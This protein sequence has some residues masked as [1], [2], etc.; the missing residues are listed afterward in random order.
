MNPYHKK[1]LMCIAAL[2][3]SVAALSLTGGKRVWAP[4]TSRALTTQGGLPSNRM[5]DMV[6]DAT[7]YIWLGTANGLCRYDGYAFVTFHAQDA[8]TRSMTDNVGTLHLDTLN[9]LLWIRSATFHYS[10]LDLRQGR[11]VNFAP[12]C[13]TRNTYERF[14]TEPGGIWMYEAKAG[15]RH[16][17]YA[18]GGF[19]C[20][21]YTPGNGLPKDCKVK[22]IVVGNGGSVWVLTT[23]GLLRLNG[24]GAFENLARGND[25]MMANSWG[26]LTYFLTRK[27]KVM[28]FDKE[29]R[30]VRSANMPQEMSDMGAV[31]GNMIW[32]GHWFIMKR[33]A[34]ISMDCRTMEFSMPAE[35]QMDYGIVL[36]N[37]D[38]N[39]CVADKHGT[40]WLFTSSGKM[41]RMQ[42]LQ[43]NDI[44]IT[45]KRNYSTIIADDG[46]FYIATY[47]SG[48]YIYDPASDNLEHFSAKDPYP[49]LDTDYL[50]NIH[51]DRDGNVWIGQEDAGVTMLRSNPLSNYGIMM[52]DPLHQGEKTNFIT[53]LRHAADG[54]ILVTTQSLRNYL[55]RKDG[56]FMPATVS[57]TPDSHT[58]SLTD[59]QGRTWI[60]TW[61]QGLIMAVKGKEGQRKLTYLLTRSITESRINALTTDR[62]GNLWVATYNGIYTADIS[63]GNISNASFRHIG[64]GDRLPTN[65]ITC[66]LSA[67]DGSVWAGGAGSGAIRCVM[68]KG[69]PDISIV[70]TMHGLSNNNI[71]SMTED[72][73]GNVWVTTDEAI[74]TI[75][76]KTMK[77]V[78]H[79]VSTSLLNRLYSDNCALTLGDGRLLFGTHDG[80]TVIT[81]QRTTTQTPRHTTAHITDILINGAS[82]YNNE[83]Y[84]NLVAASSIALPYDENTIQL[85]FSDFYYANA[86]QTL[87]QYYLEGYDK[88]WRT[89]SARNHV[90]Y[91]NLPPGTYTFHLRLDSGATETVLQ[92][93]IRQPWYNTWWA[94]LLYLT[95]AGVIATVFYRHKRQ[96]IMLRQQVMM[97]KEV[98]DM[99][100]NLF[101]QIAHEFRTP[102]AIISGAIDRM[103][104]SATHKKPLQTAKRGTVRMTR[105]VNQLM[106]FRKIDTDNLRLHVEHG[107][108]V[109]FIRDISHDFWNIANQKEISLSFQSSEKVLTMPF[110]RHI[111]DAITYN[112]ISNAVK[113]TPA[114]GSVSIRLKAGERQLCI[115]VDD[116]GPGIDDSRLPMLFQPFMH[117]FA[118][119]GGMGIG[120]YTAQKMA[121]THKGSLTYLRSDSLGGARFT[122]TLPLNDDAYSA[123]D[124]VSDNSAATTTTT[125]YQE[126]II[127]EMLPQALNNLHIA[128]IEDDPDMLE[129]IKSEMGVYFHVDA[130]TT[131]KD[132]YDNVCMNKPSLLICDVTLPDM[133][134][135]DIV[136]QLRSHADTMLIPVIMLTALDDDHHRIKG[137]EAGAD[138]YM[139]KPC[140]YQ[141]LTVRATQLI[142]WSRER[143]ATTVATPPAEN[144]A[145]PSETMEEPII[146]SRAD[147]RFAEQV[148]RI[149]AL[150]LGDPDFS[151]DQ[152]AEMLHIGRTKLFGKI[153]ELKGM[154]PNKLLVSERM[155]HAAQL[156]EDG[157]LNISEVSYKVGIK[158]AS[159]FNRCFKQ[160]YGISP[161]QY[162]DKG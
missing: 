110:D 43:E 63:H 22:R 92:I 61:E 99:R 123:E 153:K 94:W 93:R 3:C 95:I 104:D 49:I 143:K 118:S 82:I 76:P 8:D 58:D 84:A 154:S 145:Q 39:M 107:D 159:Y 71:H 134:G 74:S 34:V 116:S 146:T 13:D 66:L 117:G 106:E 42:L 161:K 67:S 102:L 126:A 136:R 1:I 73:Y 108:I 87:Y 57:A 132:G 30:M 5:N 9:S 156:L 83:K 115:I 35:M 14:A 157:S 114:K 151:V 7:G 16:V 149:I 75:N 21:D 19:S 85:C 68:K 23:D 70:S 142:K 152:M 96:Q 37:L 98:A 45:K 77:A 131:G 64:I 27:G 56:T 129:Q 55:L 121:V 40:F 125:K 33:N 120:L 139:V 32:Q 130:Y 155:K 4:L 90:E 31:N 20:R 69:K 148:D 112:I 100:I 41:K 29:G 15:I 38:G 60:A 2:A 137:Y 62:Q 80:I 89:P 86:G 72:R 113:Y 122:L 147:K 52:P 26:G 48:L 10:C 97:E 17:T 47:G 46:K 160:H 44:N 127:H 12:G 150:H 138:D 88:T 103:S 101:T 79:N 140:N 18:D 162:R 25:F 24:K 119:Q 128:V 135:Y 11:Y 158:D 144:A 78:N 65:D 51:K 53:R 109:R 36:D 54:N 141:V 59:R 91:G 6:Q 124:Y 111:V 50:I 133:S 105:L 28:V 81:P